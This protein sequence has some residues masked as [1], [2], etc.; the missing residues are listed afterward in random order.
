MGGVIKQCCNSGKFFAKCSNWVRDM[1]IRWTL[2]HTGGVLNVWPTM[3]TCNRPSV[4]PIHAPNTKMVHFRAM[5]TIKH[6]YKKH[7]AGSQAHSSAWSPEAA[8][9]TM[10]PSTA[11]SLQK[12]SP[13]GSTINL[14]PSDSHQQRAHDFAAWLPSYYSD[15]LSIVTY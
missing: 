15:L 14:T 13:G 8:K 9:M 6:E 11:T 2:R 5:V 12:H 4:S 7:Q 10:K 1:V 3:P